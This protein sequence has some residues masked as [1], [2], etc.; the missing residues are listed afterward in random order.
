VWA[1]RQ[2]ETPSPAIAITTIIVLTRIII[3][4]RIIIHT[5][6][7]RWRALRRATGRL[8]PPLLYAAFINME[9]KA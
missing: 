6:A 4:T 2:L 5:E 7:R 3:I 1:A 8:R 9:P